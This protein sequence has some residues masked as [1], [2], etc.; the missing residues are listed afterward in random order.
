MTASRRGTVLQMGDA[1]ARVDL[2]WV[3]LY[4]LDSVRKAPWE[5]ELGEQAL[6]DAIRRGRVV[7]VSMNQF[8]ASPVMMSLLFSRGT[9]AEGEELDEQTL[10]ILSLIRQGQIVLARFSSTGPAFKGRD[11][12]RGVARPAAD[13]APAVHECR[14]IT[15]YLLEA[16]TKDGFRFSSLPFLN[17]ENVAARLAADGCGGDVARDVYHALMD[18]FFDSIVFD[19][20]ERFLHFDKLYGNGGA[21]PSPLDA[22]QVEQAVSFIRILSVVERDMTYVD[23][24]N[25][26]RVIGINE[27]VER[28]AGAC[29]R[30]IGD[31]GSLGADG[32]AAGCAVAEADVLEACAFVRRMARSASSEGTRAPATRSG[33]YNA[34]DAEPGL[35]RRVAH[36]ARCIVDIAYNATVELNMVGLDPQLACGPDGVDA[37]NRLRRYMAVH[38]A[39]A[40]SYTSSTVAQCKERV[41]AESDRCWT[42]LVRLTRGVELSGGPGSRAS[43][44][45]PA[46]LA[47]DAAWSRHVRRRWALEVVSF[48]RDVLLAVAVSTVSWVMGGAGD[49]LTSAF[50]L[51][52][53]GQFVVQV[54]VLTIVFDRVSNAFSI[55]DSVEVDHG[56]RELYRT[57][58]AY[59]MR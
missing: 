40:A 13:A 44:Q 2:P 52:V 47:F 15:Q 45:A 48:L 4:E 21:L 10:Q 36:A 18:C 6:F 32:A 53:A 11:V 37:V 17:Y 30:F 59:R 23:G 27:A 31:G 12:A 54:I 42:G 34:I 33:Y 41:Q 51:G 16:A 35:G 28:L 29:E 19:E 25:S 57:F 14:T 58:K 56:L 24:C 8:A 46:G 49:V 38:P 3:Y 7:V 55:R 5:I 1:M 39:D 22:A 50:N 20:P 9:H 26:A 43:L